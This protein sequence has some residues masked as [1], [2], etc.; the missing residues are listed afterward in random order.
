MTD[1]EVLHRRWLRTLRP[2]AVA[3]VVNVIMRTDFEGLE[4]FADTGVRV[5]GTYEQTF[6]GIWGTSF[7]DGD[8][9]YFLL[10]SLSVIRSQAMHSTLIQPA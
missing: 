6:S 3:G 2:D 7:N 10:S 9:L 8:A 4:L 5:G 1:V